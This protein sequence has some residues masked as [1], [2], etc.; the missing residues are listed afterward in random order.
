[1]VKQV[2]CRN[3]IEITATEWVNHGDHP[4]VE[5]LPDEVSLPPG[6]NKD[7]WGCIKGPKGINCFPPHTMIIETGGN[8]FPV[9]NQYYTEWYEE[10]DETE[11]MAYGYLKSLLKNNAPELE[12]LPNLIGIATQIDNIIAGLKAE[13]KDNM[14]NKD[15]HG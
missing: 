15:S 12:P 5:H 3:R 4:F 6:N 8:T 14:D 1:M 13:L 2:K 11:L 7:V 9:D 10:I